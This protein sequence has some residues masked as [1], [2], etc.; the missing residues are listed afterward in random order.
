MQEYLPF[1]QSSTAPAPIT[2]ATATYPNNPD[3][4]ALI[5]AKFGVGVGVGVTELVTGDAGKVDVEA[6]SKTE[7]VVEDTPDTF[8][9]EEEAVVAVA[10]AV[11]LSSKLAS[12]AAMLM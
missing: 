7:G 11:I 9:A 10:V 5:S 3:P 12:A 1:Y 2:P 4:T 8:G 6:G